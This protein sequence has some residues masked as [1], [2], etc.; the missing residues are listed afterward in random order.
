[1]KKQSHQGVT[2]QKHRQSSRETPQSLKLFYRAMN[3]GVVPVAEALEAT[4]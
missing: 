2:S 4:I 1:M 3:F